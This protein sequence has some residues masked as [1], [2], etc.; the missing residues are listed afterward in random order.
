VKK[1]AVLMG[2]VRG[3]DLQGVQRRQGATADNMSAGLRG[4][5]KSVRGMTV[6][7]VVL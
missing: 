6:R 7:V 1:L 5:G 4:N 3:A 2:Q